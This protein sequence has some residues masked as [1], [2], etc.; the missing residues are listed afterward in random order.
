MMT[1]RSDV[2]DDTLPLTVPDW[3]DNCNIRQMG[4]SGKRV[5]SKNVVSW[6]QVSSV[7]LMLISHRILHT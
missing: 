2:E 6:F 3:S 1:A 7:L 5:V 4:S